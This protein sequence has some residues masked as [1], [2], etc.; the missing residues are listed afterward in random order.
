MYQVLINRMIYG[1]YTRDIAL[2]VFE[3]LKNK[4]YSAEWRRI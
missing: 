3:M 4:G 1:T 2:R